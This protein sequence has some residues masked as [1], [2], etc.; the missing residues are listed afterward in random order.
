M[1]NNQFYSTTV[2][3]N[4]AIEGNASDVFTVRAVGTYGQMSAPATVATSAKQPVSTI[5][6]RLENKRLIFSE[7]VVCAVYTVDA[8]L[9]A[10][11]TQGI[12]EIELPQMPQGA[13]IVKY[14]NAQGRNFQQV[15]INTHN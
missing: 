6:M 8:K 10:Y 5:S 3:T 13:F 12:T 15:L 1:K 11:T 14:S 9:I 7:P 4:A 2:N